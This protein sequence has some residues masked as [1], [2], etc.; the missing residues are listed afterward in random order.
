MEGPWACS[1]RAKNGPLG[2]R[3]LQEQESVVIHA[4]GN[5]AVGLRWLDGVKL[6]FRKEHGRHTEESKRTKDSKQTGE[7]REGRATSRVGG[8]FSF[9]LGVQSGGDSE[10]RKPAAREAQNAAQDSIHRERQWLRP[11]RPGSGEGAGE[12]R[13]GL[14]WSY[15]YGRT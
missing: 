11:R 10:V 8:G 12:G 6:L 4:A 9:R 1:T 7:S 5:L 15:L 13:V 2:R 14:V 3:A